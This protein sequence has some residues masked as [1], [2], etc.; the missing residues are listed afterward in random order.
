M[1][2]VPGAGR[3]AAR[4]HGVV[5]LRYPTLYPKAN[6]QKSGISWKSWTSCDHEHHARVDSCSKPVVTLNQHCQYPQLGAHCT[7]HT[8]LAGVTGAATGNWAGWGWVVAGK[9]AR[10]EGG[11]VMAGQGAGAGRG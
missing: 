5:Y 4:P 11:W 3:S 1:V 6:T 9:G 2:V 10:G 8:H 7:M